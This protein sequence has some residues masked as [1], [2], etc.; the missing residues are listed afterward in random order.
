MPSLTAHGENTMRQQEETGLPMPFTTCRDGG[1][2]GGGREGGRDR[3]SEGDREGG[4][5]R[6]RE[7]ERQRE[8]DC[9]ETSKIL[10]Q[11]CK[12]KRRETI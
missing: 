3:G 2:R 8:T 9:Q 11:G 1:E 6:E 10:T 12:T 4:K 5:K 7:I